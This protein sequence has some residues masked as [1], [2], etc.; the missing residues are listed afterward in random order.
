M[1]IGSIGCV[2]HIPQVINSDAEKIQEKI[3]KG[4]KEPT[5]VKKAEQTPPK[6][7]INV[8]SIISEIDVPP[9]NGV[10]S[11]FSLFSMTLIFFNPVHVFLCIYL[12]FYVYLFNISRKFLCIQAHELPQKSKLKSLSFIC[13]A[14]NQPRHFNIF[15]TETTQY[16]YKMI[17]SKFNIP[18]TC[19]FCIYAGVRIIPNS[20]KYYALYAMYW[21]NHLTA[22]GT[23]NQ[24]ITT[25]IFYRR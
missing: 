17:A 19:T 2:E 14:G 15:H 12:H 10:R 20:S 1:L 25:S 7:N 3:L 21:T 5:T 9:Q 6:E 11:I 13:K 22:K 16:L 8:Q 18:S 24:Y 4:K 23:P